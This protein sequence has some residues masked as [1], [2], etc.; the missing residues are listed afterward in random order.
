MR[1][2]TVLAVISFAL[3]SCKK[4]SASNCTL[5]QTSYKDIPTSTSTYEFDDQ[6]RLKAVTESGN[7][8]RQE[9][10]YYKDSVVVTVGGTR[11]TYYLNSN[12]LANSAIITFN[13]NPD[14]LGF[15]NTYTYNSEGY[16]TES[17]E[18]FKQNHNGVTLRDTGNTRFTYENGNLIKAIYAW[19][20]PVEIHYEYTTIEA[21][22][23]F[24]QPGLQETGSFLG[25]RSKNLLSQTKD[26]AG[27]ILSTYSYEFDS[28]GNVTKR[29]ET[30]QN[31]T[32][33]EILF[34]HRCH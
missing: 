34:T 30:E 29:I 14:G 21:V 4:D 2:F 25:K 33:T 20:G 1:K 12:G 16:L 17:Q 19:G 32:K 31:G 24:F 11:T 23:S 7:N 27:N 10:N 8:A 9:Y 28:N 13:P 5:Y 22:H 6:G 18:I 3:A 26:Q 15:N